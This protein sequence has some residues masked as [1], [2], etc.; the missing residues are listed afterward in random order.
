[1][2]K[3]TIKFISIAFATIMI[4]SLPS[5]I[6]FFQRGPEI[7]FVPDGPIEVGHPLG[8]MAGGILYSNETMEIGKDLG[9]TW[10]RMDISWNHVERE[11]GIFN[12]TN[13]DIRIDNATAMGMEILVVLAYDNNAVEMDPDSEKYEDYIAPS[14]VPKYVEYVN[15]TISHYYPM[16]VTHF[17]IWN[18]PN[19]PLF[20][21]GPWEDFYYLFEETVKFIKTHFP[22]VFI[23]AP[24][25]SDMGHA[26]LKQLFQEG[27]LQQCEAISFHTYHQYNEALIERIWQLRDL[28]KMF[29][30]SGELWLT[31]AGFPTGGTYIHAIDEQDQGDRLLKSITLSL[32]LGIDRE[33][34]YTFKDGDHNQPLNSESYFGLLFNDY[35]YKTSAYAFKFFN[36][37]CTNS[38]LRTDLITVT[39]PPSKNNLFA[40]LYQKE[41]LT[42]TLVIWYASSLVQDEKITV[43]LDIPYQPGTLRVHS[44]KDGSSGMVTKTNFKVGYDSLVLTFTAINSS[45]SVGIH[46]NPSGLRIFSYILIGFGICLP[47]TIWILRKSKP[48]I[49]EKIKGKYRS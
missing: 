6:Y 40:F 32:A 19:L 13:Y 43:R 26:F 38:T 47:I 44:F 12:F 49:L 5:L 21:G 22:D 48:Q 15:Q 28:C 14:D 33:F 36:E 37:Y 7:H 39:G 46:V 9:V 3:I 25:I 18:E 34:W 42:S 10:G 17:E 24:A 16:N 23:V 31:E 35:S 45:S 30:Y 20:W 27:Y 1:M 8:T 11:S 29:N 41:N 2:K 4:L